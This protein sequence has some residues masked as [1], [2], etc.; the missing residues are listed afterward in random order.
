MQALP[1]FSGFYS[2]CFR[3]ILD[4]FRIFGSTRPQYLFVYWAKYDCRHGTHLLVLR[5]IAPQV[6]IALHTLCTLPANFIREHQFFKD[7]SPDSCILTLPR[8]AWQALP[9]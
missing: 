9:R 4:I 8:L 1:P 6:E 2:L 3:G 5:L 7:D